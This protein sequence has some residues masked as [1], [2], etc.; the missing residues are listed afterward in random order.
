MVRNKGIP[1]NRRQRR[2]AGQRGHPRLTEADIRRVAACPDCDADVD[3][4]EAEPG[5]YSVAV[6]HDDTCPWFAA[7]QRSGGPSIRFGYRPP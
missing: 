5:V 4:F 2:A 1:V 6:M 3:G 7:F